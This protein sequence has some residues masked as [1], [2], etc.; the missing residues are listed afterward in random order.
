MKREYD[1]IMERIQV[2]TEMRTRILEHLQGAGLKPAA[3][4]IPFPAL[5]K[6]G[7]IAA[8]LV[9]LLVGAIALPHLLN[10]TEPEPPVLT[11]PNIVE[12][13]SIQ[14]LSELVGFEVTTDFSLPFQAETVTYCS[15]WNEMAQIE[16]SGEGCSAMYRQSLGTDDNSGDYNTYGDITVMEVNGLDITLKGE[17]GI[18]TLAVWTDGDCAYSLSL[19]LGV[20]ADSWQ[21]ILTR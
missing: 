5:K 12:A 21:S 14:E 6:Y 11:G 20:N 2:T 16:Y 15:Y 7:S 13:A 4:V 3:R 17:N 8:C 18:Y 9:L 19:S 10:P 1:E